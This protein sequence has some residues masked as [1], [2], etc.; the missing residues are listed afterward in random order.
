MGLDSL[1]P[2]LLGYENVGIIDATPVTHTRPVGV[3]R[4]EALRAR[5]L[6]ESDAIMIDHACSQRHVIFGGWAPDM[7]PLAMSPEQLL[8]EVVEG[9]DYLIERDPRVLAWI[10]D[11]ERPDAG[12]LDYPVAGTPAGME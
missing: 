9:S 4:D 3:M 1:W 2:K 11:F 8:A 12:W 7:T 6:V 10:A 5:V